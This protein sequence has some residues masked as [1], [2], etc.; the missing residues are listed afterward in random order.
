MTSYFLKLK[1]IGKAILR[2]LHVIC[3]ANTAVAACYTTPS[4]AISAT[5]TSLSISEREGYRVVKIQSDLV[6]G[7]TWATIIDC[8]HPLWPAVALQL[9]SS[10][11]KTGLSAPEP[12]KNASSSA[13]I[14][15]GE[16]VRLWRQETLLRIEAVG[17]SEGNGG[18]GDSVKVRILCRNSDDKPAAKEFYGVVRGPSNVEMKP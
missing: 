8:G 4:H 15:A 13:M 6:L 16:P 14:R 2:A 5:T 11:Y 18:L 1:M 17:I 12:V 10:H 3:F 9:K 7:Q